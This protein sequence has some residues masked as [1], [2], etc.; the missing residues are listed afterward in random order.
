[1]FRRDHVT[2]DRFLF[3][4]QLVGGGSSRLDAAHAPTHHTLGCVL[5]PHARLVG[6]GDD[7]EHAPIVSAV[8]VQRPN[9][10]LILSRAART[11]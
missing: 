11:P 1:M 6:R 7:V 5:L 2:H 4:P 9:A 10:E 8:Q 3:V